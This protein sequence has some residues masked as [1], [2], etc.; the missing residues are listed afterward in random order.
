MISASPVRR[1]A[2]RLDFRQAA[3][4]RTLGFAAAIGVPIVVV[5]LEPDALAD[6]AAGIFVR[7]G[8]GRMGLDCHP[9][10]TPVALLECGL[11]SVSSLE[12]TRV[13]TL[14][15]NSRVM[16]TQIRERGT[17]PVEIFA[18]AYSIPI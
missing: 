5:A 11:G 12:A 1:E 14:R 7:S 3:E 6:D 15:I 17:A 8:P 13:P 16:G 2:S 18:D 4:D 10:R 9:C